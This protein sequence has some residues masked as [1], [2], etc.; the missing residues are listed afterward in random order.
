MALQEF[1]EQGGHVVASDEA[2]DLVIEHF[3][4]PVANVTKG[5]KPEEFY[6]AGSILRVVCDPR[7]PLA[8]G[9]PERAP[10]FFTR[11][12][13]F[14]VVKDALPDPERKPPADV[15][16]VRPAE[17]ARRYPTVA[18]VHYADTL[19]LQSG[20]CHKPE[21]I[22]GQAAIVQVRYGAGTV[23]L[24]GFRTQ[25]RGQP[26][27]TFRFLFNALLAPGMHQAP[28]PR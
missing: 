21:L 13:A 16:G 19:L 20:Y 17:A 26:Q 28:M 18:P 5:K 2:C 6:C 23:T 7:H 8:F 14:A 12:Q 1:A 10:A 15:P 24:L 11:S 27:G 9:M 3:Q 4:L 22:A 25:H